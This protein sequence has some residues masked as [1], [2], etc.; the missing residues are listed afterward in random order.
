MSIDLS[1]FH[2]THGHARR[3]RKHYL[4]RAWCNLKTL[5]YNPAAPNYRLYG[6]VGV[7]MCAAWKDSYAQFAEDVLSTIGERPAGYRFTRIDN[8]GQFAPGNV[9]WMTPGDI[10]RK[11]RRLTAEVVAQVAESNRG[12]KH[13]VARVRRQR[14]G[15]VAAH[16]QGRG[17][18]TPEQNARHGKIMRKLWREGVYDGRVAMMR[19]KSAG[20]QSAR[21][22]KRTT[23]GTSK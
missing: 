4:Y 18:R 11:G 23:N 14:A 5:C 12:K 15:I 19:A 17:V 22:T 1:A 9:A 3:G 6:A 20:K 13:P 2:L 16:A 21:K 7:G 8:A 10:D